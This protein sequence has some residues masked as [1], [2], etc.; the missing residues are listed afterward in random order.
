MS[1][2]IVTGNAT[3]ADALSTGVFVLGLE[4]GMGLIEQL[5][6]VEGIIVYEDTDSGLSTKASSGMQALFK[7]NNEN[8]QKETTP[9]M[10]MSGS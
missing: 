6:D 4:K 1:V 9:D 3:R 5:P 7:E 8:S 2:T 10:I